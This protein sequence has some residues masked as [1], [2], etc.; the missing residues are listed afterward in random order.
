MISGVE[1][2]WLLKEHDPTRRSL[3]ISHYPI[4]REGVCSREYDEDPECIK[5]HFCSEVPLRYRGKSIVCVNGHTYYSYDF[6]RNRVRYIS[7]ACGYK[8]ENTGYDP[9]GVYEI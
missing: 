1:R 4:T 2:E 5:S 6:E 7:N 9:D 3:I 8:G